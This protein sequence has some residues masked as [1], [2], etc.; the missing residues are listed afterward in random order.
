M[1][2]DRAQPGDVINTAINDWFAWGVARYS[3]RANEYKYAPSSS[4]RA[5]VLDKDVPC[6]RLEEYQVPGGDSLLVLCASL[7]AGWENRVVRD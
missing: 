1:V 7:P 4:G 2:D 3:P 5:W 6:T